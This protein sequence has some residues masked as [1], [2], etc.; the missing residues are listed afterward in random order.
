MPFAKNAAGKWVASAEAG[1]S[2]TPV[3]L[4]IVDKQVDKDGT[5]QRA[6]L[7][8]VKAISFDSKVNTQAE[9]FSSIRAAHRAHGKPFVSLA[10]ANHGPADAAA[11]WTIASDL[12]V[13]VASVPEAIDALARHIIYRWESRLLFLVIYTVKILHSYA[14]HTDLRVTAAASACFTPRDSSTPLHTIL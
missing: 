3:R 7:K 12:T 14:G 5:F 4:V 1:P 8:D 6:P 13:P 9:L 11:P 2:D 10:F